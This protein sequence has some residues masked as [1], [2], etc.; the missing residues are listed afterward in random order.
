MSTL[1][2]AAPA[3]LN[4]FL[5]VLGRRADGYHLL[6]TVFQLLDLQDDVT[7]SATGDGLIR[8][9]PPPDDAVLAALPDAADLCVK[10]ALRLQAH[11]GCKLGARIHVTKRIP[12]GG[13]LGGGSSDAAAVLLG[14]NQ[15]W[16]LRLSLDELARLG[17]ALGADVPVFV[18]GHN[19]WAEGLGEQLMPLQLP[20]RWFVVLRPPVSI[21]TAE[22]FSAPELT[23]DTPPITIAAFLAGHGRN[24]CEPVVRSRYPVVAEALDWLGQFAPARLTG[25]GSCL[26]AAFADESA[27]RVVAAAPPPGCQAWAVRGIG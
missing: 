23:R 27:A 19:A 24:D 1:V 7:V 22:V 10:A 14:L 2:L 4:L 18:H 12:A 8:R 15:L 3:K 5:H 25:T 17:L 9:D 6:Q 16:D 21:S 20:Q 13:G 26:F 11:T